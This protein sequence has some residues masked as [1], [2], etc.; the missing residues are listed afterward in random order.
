MA[1]FSGVTNSYLTLKTPMLGS[2][3][4]QG[5]LGTNWVGLSCQWSAKGMSEGSRDKTGALVNGGR[6]TWAWKGLRDL[7]VRRDK[8]C[9][10]LKWGSPHEMPPAAYQSAPIG[11]DEQSEA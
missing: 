3:P 7:T 1:F 6:H 5:P 2:F 10:K 9:S 11:T 4:S 8:L